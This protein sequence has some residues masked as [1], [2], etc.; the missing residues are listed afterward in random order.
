MSYIPIHTQH[1][2]QRFFLVGDNIMPSLIKIIFYSSK[3]RC[4]F[5]DLIFSN[6]ITENGEKRD[7]H[8][9]IFTSTKENGVCHDQ[10]R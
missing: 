6:K 2:L 3:F 10:T 8:I 7:R 1:V 4:I 9:V 5:S